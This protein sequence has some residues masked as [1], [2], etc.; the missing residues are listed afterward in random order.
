MH[1]GA[2]CH[3]AKAV[4]KFLDLDPTENNWNVMKN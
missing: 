4:K 1:D 3:K 2:P